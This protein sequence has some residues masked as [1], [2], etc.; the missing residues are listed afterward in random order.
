MAFSVQ[1]RG[2]MERLGLPRSLS[3]GYRA[4]TGEREINQ[5]SRHLWCGRGGDIQMRQ[6]P[7]QLAPID[8]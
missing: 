7:L 4:Q 5:M 6:Q 8:Q 1:S 3:P 2:A